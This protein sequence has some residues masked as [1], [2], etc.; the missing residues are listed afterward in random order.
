MAGEQSE[1]STSQMGLNKSSPE[2]N[3]N[4][5]EEAENIARH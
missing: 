1:D 3:V 4:S 5:A 2:E